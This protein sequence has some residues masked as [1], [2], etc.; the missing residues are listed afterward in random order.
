M[1]GNHH[2][3]RL[4][5]ELMR[6]RRSGEK[7]VAG[8]GTKLIDEAIAAEE[9]DK[10]CKALI[11]ALGDVRL[12]LVVKKYDQAVGRLIEAIQLPIVKVK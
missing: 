7:P 9:L 5:Q 6:R 8:D 2:A 4:G 12:L 1:E 10:K 11:T 3:E